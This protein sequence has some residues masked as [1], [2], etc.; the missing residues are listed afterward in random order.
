M[1][2]VEGLAPVSPKLLQRLDGEIARFEERLAASRPITPTRPTLDTQALRKGLPPETTLIAYV[3]YGKGNAPHYGAFL[4]E[5]EKDVRFQDLGA[6]SR[7]DTLVTSQQT[8]MSKPPG[9]STWTPTGQKRRTDP[10]APP[11]ATC[12]WT[13]SSA[14]TSPKISC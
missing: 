8:L 1:D 12:C 2:P 13:P 6:A 14:A 4:M 10:S 5:P 3:Q 11:S 7:I 9:T